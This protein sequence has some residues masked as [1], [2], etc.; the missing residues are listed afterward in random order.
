MPGGYF[1]GAAGLALGAGA[2]EAAG[3]GA[4]V[5]G[6]RRRAGLAAAAAWGWAPGLI[7]Q[8]W[9]RLSRVSATLSIDLSAEA[10]QAAE[11]RL[12]MAA[13]AAEP[14]VEVEVPERGVEVVAP[15]QADDAAAE[16]DAFGVAARAVDG[17]GRLDE[18]VGLALVVL[19]DVGGIGGRRLA[20]LILGIGGAALGKRA[21]DPIRR[22]RPAAAKRRKTA[23]LGSSTRRRIH[24]PISFLPR[25][26]RCDGLA[27]CRPNWSPMRRTRSGDSHDGY[28]GFCPAKSQLYH[29]GGKTA[30]GGA[31]GIGLPCILAERR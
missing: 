9:M 29:G 30:A 25:R 22:A 24:S 10:G 27:C 2:G 11:G 16:P 19:V 28:F 5:A 13:G 7:Q 17:L 31:G 8:T 20:G 6:G 12:D 3:A 4:G 18:F 23:T 21:A 1:A 14:V 15:H 26:G